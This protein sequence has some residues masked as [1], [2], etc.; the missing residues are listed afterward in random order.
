M[1]SRERKTKQS[2]IY[3]WLLG[4]KI[5]ETKIGII[6]RVGDVDVPFC[7]CVRAA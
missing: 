6:T 5:M 7:D 3:D 4:E 2:L 1:V